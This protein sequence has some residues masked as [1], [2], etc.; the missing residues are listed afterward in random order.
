M[1][2]LERLLPLVSTL[3]VLLFLTCSSDSQFMDIEQ[4][5][6]KRR[7]GLLQRK[8]ASSEI[9]LAGLND[10]TY[11]KGLFNRAV[12]AQVIQN[13]SSNGARAIFYDVLFEESRD[14]AIDQ[15]LAD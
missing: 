1:P 8:R 12:H 3:L 5:L 2:M 11:K 15:K 13:L 4:G 6:V 10:E 14:P 9:V 7:L